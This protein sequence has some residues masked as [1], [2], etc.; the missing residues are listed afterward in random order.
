MRSFLVAIALAL[1][2]SPFTPEVAYCQPDEI[3]IENHADGESAP[4]PQRRPTRRRGWRNSPVVWGGVA[5][6][7]IVAI[8]LGV[9]KTVCQ[10]RAWKDQQ[11]RDKAPWERSMEQADR[12]RSV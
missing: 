12:E 5:L 10:M 2:I 11:Q 6:V 1:A 4:P 7:L 3:I 8:P 9:F